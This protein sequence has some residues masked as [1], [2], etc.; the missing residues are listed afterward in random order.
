MGSAGKVDGCAL[1]WKQA[2]LTLVE[3]YAVEFNEVARQLGKKRER[4]GSLD[5]DEASRLVHRLSKDN[6]AQI[7]VL[8]MIGANARLPTGSGG[9]RGRQGNQICIVNTHIY[10]N[11]KLVDVKLWQT[12]TL[13]NEVESHV[14]RRDIPTLMCGDFNSE[15]Q[16]VV[17]QFLTHGRVDPNH[18]DIVLAGSSSVISDP[19]AISHNV[20]IE[21]AMVTAT[22]NEPSFTN[23]TVG[24]IGT[25]DYIWYTPSSIRVLAAMSLPEADEIY[26]TSEG[27]PSPNRPSDHV[28]LC[29]DIAVMSGSNGGL[30][31]NSTSQNS[32]KKY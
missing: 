26:A 31:G 3:K 9:S 8:E 23:F 17:Y 2:K 13:M 18:E 21:S 12:V 1:L 5:K 20:H 28:M 6:V 25:L 32:L 7:V 4:E 19:N 14:G 29:V 22:G 11:P 27:L 16:S 30:V 24:F 10:A 15:P